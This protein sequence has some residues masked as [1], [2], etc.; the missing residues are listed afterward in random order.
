M[1]HASIGVQLEACNIE[2]LAGY[3][4]GDEASIIRRLAE[5]YANHNN[6]ELILL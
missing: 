4:P 2:K 3:G 6:Y 1:L 5:T